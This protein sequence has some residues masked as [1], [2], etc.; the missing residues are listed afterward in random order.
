MSLVLDSCRTPFETVEA[1]IELKQ[2]RLTSVNKKRKEIDRSIQQISD[3]Y[4]TVERDIE[5]VSK[6]NLKRDMLKKLNDQLSATEST[7]ETNVAKVINLLKSNDFV[8]QDDDKNILSLKGHIATNL[9]EVHCLVF[10]ELIYSGKF[11]QFEAKELVGI[12][13]CFTNITVPE[14][15]RYVLPT[16]D[17]TNVKDCI[18]EIYDMYQ[19]QSDL[20]LKNQYGEKNY[21]TRN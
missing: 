4:K 12:L 20:E 16:S 7:L 15:K 2:A 19:K 18:M 17:H 10:S 1:Y 21:V 5:I 9:R 13:S 14:D 11:K 8:K 6:F 3:Q